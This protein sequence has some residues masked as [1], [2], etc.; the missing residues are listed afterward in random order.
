MGLQRV[1]QDWATFTFP[2]RWK[3]STDER[4]QNTYTWRNRSCSW[5]G[6]IYIVKMNIQP[7][8]VNRFSAIP[9]KLPTIFFIKL[10]Q[11][12][13]PFARK[14]IKPWRAKA[15]LR[16]KNGTRRVKLSDFRLHHKDIKRVWNLHKQKYRPMEQNRQS[17]YKFMHPSSLTME[18]KYATENI[19]FLHKMLL[20]KLDSYV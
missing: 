15:I 9:L 16:K 12:I 11:I 6:W 13:L 10:K 19:Y 1:R 5:T 18:G 17:K 8:A 14:H 20:G 3:I 2:K 4:K 7:K